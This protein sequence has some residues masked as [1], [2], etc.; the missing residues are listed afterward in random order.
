MYQLPEDVSYLAS[1]FYKHKRCLAMASQQF[2]DPHILLEAY[3]QR[4]RRLDMV[5][6]DSDMLLLSCS[7]DHV[8]G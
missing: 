1:D 3:R 5:I 4:A 2:S 7:A 8:L 6:L